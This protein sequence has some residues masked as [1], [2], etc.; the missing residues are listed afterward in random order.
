MAAQGGKGRPRVMELRNIRQVRRLPAGRKPA[1]DEQGHDPA[2]LV[3]IGAG[4]ANTA[5][6][7]EGL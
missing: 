4:I 5:A 2:A 3:L 1:F 7:R 6:R